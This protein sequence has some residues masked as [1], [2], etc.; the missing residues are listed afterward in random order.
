M[1]VSP[2]SNGAAPGVTEVFKFVFDVFIE[3]PLTVVVVNV[4]VLFWIT[5]VLDTILYFSCIQIDFPLLTLW[6]NIDNF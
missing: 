6:I 3:L 1:R 4:N 2:F 5:V